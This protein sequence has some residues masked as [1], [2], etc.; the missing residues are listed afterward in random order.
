MA[1]P[2][3]IVVTGGFSRSLKKLS[4]QRFEIIDVYQ[5]ALEALK[6]TLSILRAG[7][8]SKSCAAFHPGMGGGA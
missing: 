2:S 7:M 6:R 1:A 5:A 3:Q 8:T 4:Q